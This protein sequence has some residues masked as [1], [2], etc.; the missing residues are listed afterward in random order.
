[1]IAI[2]IM[3]SKTSYYPLEIQDEP[4]IKGS[5]SKMLPILR[6]HPQIQDT[7]QAI[8]KRFKAFHKISFESHDFSKPL[9]PSEIGRLSESLKRAKY[10]SRLG[11]ALDSIPCE[12]KALLRFFESLRHA[13]SFS[14]VHF[15][16][17]DSSTY[18]SKDLLFISQKTLHNIG[19]LPRKNM[20]L[21]FP[22][23][24]S[25]V[26]HIEHKILKSF[27]RQKSF[28]SAHCICKIGAKI[29]EIQEIITTL[30]SS[31]SLTEF[32]LT[33][34]GVDF[35][36][37]NRARLPHSIFHSLKKMKTVKNCRVY[38]KECIIDNSKLKGLFPALKEAAQAFNLEIIFKG[39]GNFA[40]FSRL[41]WWLFRRSIRNL[42][43]FH[44]VRARLI[45]ELELYSLKEWIAFN[46]ICYLSVLVMIA[47]LC[48]MH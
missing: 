13:K 8:K 12:D 36:S 46:V 5:K 30:S 16:F 4:Q 21:S 39:I 29:S 47:V 38:F 19:A 20:K 25:S 23:F 43:P 14:E 18:Y 1:M 11:I 37:D 32:S 27:I 7:K 6:Y 17:A 42:S 26:N 10:S 22:F 34:D 48:F 40:T 24:Y 9:S 28:T 35:T 3:N 41:G 31:K 33:L 44:T 2:P 45:G 15:Y